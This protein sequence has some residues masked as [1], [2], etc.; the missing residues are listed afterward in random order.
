MGRKFPSLMLSSASGPVSD[1]SD[2]E[3]SFSTSSEKA[4]IL[5]KT[6]PLIFYTPK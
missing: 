2:G 4:V 3:Q 5:I 1:I 6:R